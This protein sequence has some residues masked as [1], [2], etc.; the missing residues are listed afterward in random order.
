MWV[1]G[2][3]VE[4]TSKEDGVVLRGML[5]WGDGEPDG[6]TVVNGAFL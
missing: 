2:D 3:V 1:R 6:S 4:T 5:L